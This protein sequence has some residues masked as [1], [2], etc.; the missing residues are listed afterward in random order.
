MY[1]KKY[2]NHD[3]EWVYAYAFIDNHK[4]AAE[5]NK[6][7]KSLGLDMRLA[8]NEFADVDFN[9]FIKSRGGYKSSL[10][11]DSNREIFKSDNR[12]TAA[13]IDWRTEGVVNDVQNQGSCGSCWAFSTIG[14]LESRWAIKSK[15]LLKLSEQ[16]LVDCDKKTDQ[17]C[18]GGLMD[19]AFTYLEGAGSELESDYS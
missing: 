4:K 8:M 13:A 19:D 10:T 6:L 12:V 9:S 14:S 5:A 11:T 7:N 2:E 15:S 17:G 3:T 16:Q 1:N 18:N